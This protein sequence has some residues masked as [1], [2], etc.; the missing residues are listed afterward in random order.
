MP[1][2]RDIFWIG[3][4]WAVTGFGMQ[5]IN[6]RVGEAFD[7]AIARLWDDDPAIIVREQS[8]FNT[9]DFAKGLAVA[10]TRYHELS[11]KAP[12]PLPVET[13]LAAARTNAPAA[14]VAP[15]AAPPTEV[16]RQAAPAAESAPPAA[17]PPVVPPADEI[18]PPNSAAPPFEL[19]VASLPAK[20]GAMW[21]VKRQ[22]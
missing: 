18:V 17:P 14:A 19:R 11:R 6:R 8:W 15:S 7:V 10:R 5:V 9:E 1:L 12:P 16:T 3:R 20:L 22:K 13:R 2:H 21:R 4:Q